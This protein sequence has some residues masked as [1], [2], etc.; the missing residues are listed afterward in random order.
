MAK[1][2]TSTNKNSKQLALY[3]AKLALDKKAFNL[4]LMD[5][6]P[7]QGLNDYVLVCSAQSSV[8]AQ[9]ICDYIKETLKKE[10]L[11]ALGQEGYQQAKWI[12]LDYNDVIIHVF[13]EYVRDFYD[14]EN[15][16]Y[17]APRVKIPKTYYKT[18]G[19]K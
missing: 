13:Y 5:V 4:I 8:H 12:L 9:T 16:W 15:L 10:N 3:C 19:K 2:E 7:W 1:K 17:D 18:Y 6:S 11:Y 14:I